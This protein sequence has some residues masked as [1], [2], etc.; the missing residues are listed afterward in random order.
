VTKADLTSSKTGTYACSQTLSPTQPDVTKQVFLITCRAVNGGY[1][2]GLNGNTATFAT[3][4][5][6]SVSSISNTGTGT[7]KFLSGK[8][9]VVATG[10]DEKLFTKISNTIVP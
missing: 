8:Y 1:Q 6:L 10:G 3:K 2:I 5:N 7:L 9:S 4:L